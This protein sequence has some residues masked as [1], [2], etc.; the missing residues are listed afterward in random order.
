MITIPIGHP[1]VEEF[2]SVKRNNLDKVKYA[3]ISVKITDDFMRAVENDDLFTLSFKTKHEEIT[4]TV[5][6]KDLWQKIVQS[7]RDSAEPGI[8][9]WDRMVE[10]SPSE[11]YEGLQI[12]STNPCGEE[13]L[14]PGASCVLGSLLL[15]R[16]VDKPFT[17]EANFK[18]DKF[19]DMTERAV[20]HLDNIVELNLGKHALQEQEKAS[21]NG[22]R[23]G[24]GITG[25][26]DVLAAMNI[27]YDSEKALEFIDEVMKTKM[28][29]EYLASM[30]LAKSRGSFRKFDPERHY[31]QGF[32]AD[33]PEDVK[34]FGRVNGQRNVAIS[35][36]APSGSLSIIAQ[37]SSGI[38]PIFALKYKRYVELGNERKEFEV[39]HQGVSRYVAGTGLHELP[40]YWV[41]AHNIDHSFRVK[42][43]G[44][45]Q[46]YT[47]ASISSTINLPK[48]EVAETVGK[49]YF[50]A[51]RGKLKGVTVYREGAREG[52]LVTDDY[53]KEVMKKMDT[54]IHK[55]CAEGGDKFYIPISYKNGDIK[56]PYQVF[57]LNYKAAE[58]DR[59]V[60][61]GNDIVRML[62]G[63][64]NVD[65]KKVNKYIERSNNSL[66]K[67]TRMIS[68]SMNT[69]N[70]EDCVK[71][72]GEHAY[73]GTLAA[74]LYKILSKS[75]MIKKSM[76]QDC[77][78]SN[79][80]MEEGCMRCLDCGWSGCE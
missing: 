76:C 33:L 67:I 75:L 10:R 61:L 15:H 79:V 44:L 23:I 68:L 26:A 4:R 42:L 65:E 51:W 29:A 9:F 2:V 63:K 17:S 34:D 64:D 11:I 53:A 37:C 58:N 25:L 16:F 38:E 27:K 24:L 56:S 14:E 43:Q 40:D 54:I 49:I 59:F 30:K 1:D 5:K 70:F 50:D 39:N 21:R 74:E 71:I 78:S 22:R 20:R 69:G 47:D 77:S 80:S 57:V 55:V 72:L 18:I 41:T 35:T 31:E 7:A 32:C 12:H 13:I 60:K 36:V 28:R 3:N 19:S 52:I 46:K 6:A 62:R 48:E 73:A 45:V 66:S 8:M